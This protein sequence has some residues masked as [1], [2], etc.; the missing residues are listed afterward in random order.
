MAN[1][2]VYPITC[3]NQ[4]GRLLLTPCP[5][6]KG[7]ELVD[8]LKQFKKS[9]VTAILTLMLESEIYENNLNNIEVLCE[10]NDMQWFN[11]PIVD[12]GVPHDE[13]DLLWDKYKKEIHAILDDNESIVIHCKGGSG[14]TGLVAAKI[15]LERGADF[16]QTI[17]QIKTIRPSA[18][19]H[20]VQVEY[21][22]QYK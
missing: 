3:P 21:M 13:F 11:L 8:A 14:R 22:A 5:G 18:F 7:I 19:S 17:K 6:L 9:G 15:L 12:E 1:H 20:A 4:K 10:E 2:P 16:D